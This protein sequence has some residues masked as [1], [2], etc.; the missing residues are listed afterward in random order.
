M[1]KQRFMRAIVGL[2]IIRTSRR[3]ALG[4]QVV[5]R[6]AQV[7]LWSIM[8]KMMLALALFVTIVRMGGVE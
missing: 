3:A 1:N 2:R 4:R 5:F 8:S 6:R 7:L